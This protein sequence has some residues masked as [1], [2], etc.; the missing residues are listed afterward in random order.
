MGKL[1][2]KYKSMPVQVKASF[3]FLICFFLQK[4]ISVVTTPIFTR[5]LSTSEYGQYN[6]FNSWMDIAAIFISLNLSYGVYSQ[7]LVKFEEEKN[8]FTSSLLG[9]TTLLE[10]IWIVIYFCFR[11]FWNETFSLTTDQ[12][13]AMLI[14]IWTSAVFG[15]WS[16]EQRVQ[17]KYKVLCIITIIVSFVNPILGIALV[18]QADDKVTARILGIAVVQVLAYT[19]MFILQM[20]R[21]KKFI[22]RRFW[23]YAMMFNVPL[24]PHYLSMTVLN[25]ADRIMIK[26]MTGSGNSGIYSLA[27][28]LALIMTIFNNALMQT[29]SPWIYQKIKVKKTEDIA[30]VAYS[31]LIVIAIL[32]LLLIIFAPEI[33]RIFAPKDYY[34]AIYVIPPVAMSVFFMYSYDLFA[35]FA[36]YFEKTFFIMGASVVGAGLNVILNYIFIRHFGY[37]AA[38]YTTLFCYIVFAVCHYLF[39]NKVCDHF[40]GSIRP[41]NTKVLLGISVVFVFIGFVFLMLYDHIILRYGVITAIIIAAI[42][43]RKKILRFVNDFVKMRKVR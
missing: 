9:L 27:Y 11:S 41:Y 42:I 43:L 29:V 32:N 28:S 36:F 7:G 5:L 10:S 12:M 17:Y 4:G 16:A 20:S 35:K 31:M 6:V 37:V 25:S 13:I 23:K 15:F 19:W 22:S 24:I 1:T 18:S 40:C 39:M 26:N 8:I 38:G 30:E 34:S 2:E 21:G 3:W 33:V 14:M